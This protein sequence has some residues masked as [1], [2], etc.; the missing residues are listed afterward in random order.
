MLDANPIGE[1]TKVTFSKLL[2]T[3][4]VVSRKRRS[5]RAYIKCKKIG[6]FELC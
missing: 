3:E 2:V 4:T 1:V 6:I 5:Y